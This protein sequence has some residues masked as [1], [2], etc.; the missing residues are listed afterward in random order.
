MFV[1][2]GRINE[3]VA[4]PVY[5]YDNNTEIVHITSSEPSSFYVNVNLSSLQVYGYMVDDTTPMSVD[6][7]Y[8]GHTNIIRIDSMD[9]P[10]FWLEI[11]KN[12]FL[13]VSDS[14]SKSTC[15]KRSRN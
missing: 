13:Q 12:F 2:K 14:K 6:I 11:D 10:A 3:G 15:K 5:T 8:N 7:A 9:F 1:V 4:R